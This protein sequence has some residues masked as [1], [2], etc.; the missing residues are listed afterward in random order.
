M[1][2]RPFLDSSYYESNSWFY[3]SS[4]SRVSLQ[5]TVTV[6]LYFRSGI[7]KVLIPYQNKKDLRG[8]PLHVK[9]GLDI[10]LVKN[11]DEVIEHSFED[12]FDELAMDTLSKL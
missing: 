7:R 10:V 6:D 9:E 2:Y 12:T 1:K 11:I 4:K 8:L 3:K 5:G